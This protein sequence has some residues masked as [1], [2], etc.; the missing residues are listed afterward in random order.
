MAEIMDEL[1][2]AAASRAVKGHSSE[3][4][5]NRSNYAVANHIDCFRFLVWRLEAAAEK[6]NNCQL[7]YP[8]P[9]G[10]STEYTETFAVSQ[11][12]H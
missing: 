5:T 12:A 1:G 9:E 6:R 3:Q 8:L 11:A 2:P 4:G 10:W 7:L